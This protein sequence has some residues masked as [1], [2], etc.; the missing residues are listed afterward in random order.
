M[1]ENRMLLDEYYIENDEENNEEYLQY[2]L[3]KDD[4]RYEDEIFERLSEE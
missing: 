4:E 1:L 3:E 2:L